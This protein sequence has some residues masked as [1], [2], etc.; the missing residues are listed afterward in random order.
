MTVKKFKQLAANMNIIVKNMLVE[1]HYSIKLVKY[2]YRL[3]RSIYTIITSEIPEIKLDLALQI[4]FKALN[5]SIKLNSFI[6]ILL[7]FSAYF[8][9]IEIDAP[10]LKITQPIMARQKATEKV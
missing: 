10:S 8:W 7:V 2:Y 9:M 6:S 1:A 4:L 5:N 3:L